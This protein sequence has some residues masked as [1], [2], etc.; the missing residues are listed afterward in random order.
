VGTI[1]LDLVLDTQ[2][3]I[4]RAV[5]AADVPFVW[6]AT[7]F[8]GFT[9]GMRWNAPAGQH[10][11]IEADLRALQLWKGGRVFTF[12]IVLKSSRS[13]VGRITI[14]A[15][16]RQGDWSIGF[17]IHPE[18]WGQGFAAEA[19]RAVVE[20]GFSHL[21]ATIVRAAHAAWNVQSKRVIE[22]LG[23]RFIRE[24]PDGFEKYGQPVAELEYAL[25]R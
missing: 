3:C 18:R 21:G 12:T 10:A 15:E 22:R 1:S 19:A 14:R 8:P 5:S 17:W 7:R 6:S 11:I 9:D 4:L 2:R 23:M 25:V 24:I 16:P 13:P 20:F